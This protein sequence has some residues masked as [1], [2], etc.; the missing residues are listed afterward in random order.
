[1]VPFTSQVFFSKE[2]YIFTIIT[3]STHSTIILTMTLTN[4]PDERSF[5]IIFAIFAHVARHD[6]PTRW[7]LVSTGGKMSLLPLP[8]SSLSISSSWVP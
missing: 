5:N 7:R 3:T 4:I 8:Y 2:I 6:S 1:M